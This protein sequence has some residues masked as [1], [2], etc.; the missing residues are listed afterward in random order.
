M[1]RYCD[2]DAAPPYPTSGFAKPLPRASIRVSD[3][4]L[5]IDSMP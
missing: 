2:E 5:S 3:A 1:H 4:M